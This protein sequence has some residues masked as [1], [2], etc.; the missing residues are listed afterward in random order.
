M[1]YKIDETKKEAAYLQLYRQLRHDIT[2]GV[3]ANGAKLPS[4]RTLAAE[5]GTSVITAGHA[6]DLLS[7]EG[8]VE[9]RERSGYYVIYRSRDQFPVP[10]QGALISS[11]RSGGQIGHYQEG[12]FPFSVFART[13]RRVLTTRAEQILSRPHNSGIPE[14]RLAI[15]SY[16][17]R[18]RGMKVQPDQIIIGAG[19]EYLYS[20]VVQMIGRDRIYALEKPC[21]EKIRSV[22]EANG[23]VCEQLALD[24]EGIRSSELERTKATVL[25]VTP[26]H[27]YPSGI[28]ASASKRHEY[29]RWAKERE[30]LIVEDDYDSEF[31]EL[32]KSE[33][34][35]FSLEPDNCVLYINTFSVTIAPAM[36][37][38]Y[39]VLPG[40]RCKELYQAISFY[41]CTVP[42]FEQYVLAEFINGGDFERHINRV[43]R[44]R[45]QSE[46]GM[47]EKPGQVV[48]GREERKS[49]DPGITEM[50]GS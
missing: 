11:A 27:S 17:A 31:S 50:G 28:T 34:T 46:A 36:R 29:I 39:M 49:G 25:H 44:R 45:R 24:A 30:A 16:L 9:A 6:Y 2:D 12:Q 33:D 1:R 8:Y 14:L 7:D 40:A 47:G 23:A 4:K 18:S 41:S 13:V 37:M 21:Y 42:A 48:R 22:Y 20:M 10:D 3:Y 5:T 26:F 38:G 43:R 19:A 35:L 32:T 15:A